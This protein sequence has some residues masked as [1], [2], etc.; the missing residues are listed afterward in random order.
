VKQ[1]IVQIASHEPDVAVKAAYMILERSGSVQSDFTSGAIP[2]V[3]AIDLNLG[4]PQKIARSGNYGSFLHDKNPQSA[5]DVLSKLRSELPPEIGVTAKIRLP[6]TQ[7]DAAAGKLGNE[8]RTIP[9]PNAEERIHRLI[10][11][12]VDL[13]TVHGRTRFE[14][15]VAV[16]AANWDA[17]RRCV[18]AARLYSGDKN[19]PIFA[20]GGIESYNDVCRCLDETGASGVMSSESLLENP[21][22]FRDTGSSGEIITPRRVLERVGVCRY[23]SRLRNSVSANPGITRYKR[24]MLQRDSNAL[25]QIHSSLP[26]RKS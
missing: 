4:C 17:I 1:T 22:L 8:A 16:G 24:R 25:I 5:Y 7:A 26:G 12:G 3:A 23:V 19:F 20:N 2:P 13:I 21:G 18:E 6:P 11:S 15:K 9:P 10:D 14:N